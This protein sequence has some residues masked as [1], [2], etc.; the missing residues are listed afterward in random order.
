MTCSSYLVL[1]VVCSPYQSLRLSWSGEKVRLVV[2]LKRGVKESNTYYV[3]CYSYVTI[4][5]ALYLR[6]KGYHVVVITNNYDLRRFCYHEDF[7]V[8]YYPKLKNLKN[9][10]K[11]KKVVDDVLGCIVF[12]CNIVYQ[13]I[14]KTLECNIIIKK[15]CKRND[16]SRIFYKDASVLFYPYYRKIG[17]W[18]FYY[19]LIYRFL[20]GLRLSFYSINNGLVLGCRRSFPDEVGSSMF[21]KDVSFS[22]IESFAVHNY[23][24]R[25]VGDM[26][27]DI[28]Y[29]EFCSRNVFCFD[30]VAE[31]R[32][33]V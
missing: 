1:S 32:F 19:S 25:D 10:F 15:I 29:K 11:V 20:F 5:L 22:D 21:L 7:D 26:V 31:R 13:G 12:P 24:L 27:K 9:F 23:R 16:G 4:K 2:L 8:I 18:I 14:F 33:N 28:L 17:F 30:K 6:L 3:F